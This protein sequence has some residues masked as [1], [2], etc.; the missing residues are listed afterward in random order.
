MNI[1]RVFVYKNYDEIK[2][3]SIPKV[4][5]VYDQKEINTH[6]FIE[7]IN[8]CKKNSVNITYLKFPRFKP[9]ADYDKFITD[10]I[11]QHDTLNFQL[12]H[13]DQEI[14]KITDFKDNNHLNLSGARKYSIALNSFL[15]D[16]KY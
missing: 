14:F 3:E 4:G 13:V 16:N 12:F 8:L 9:V 5:S 6:A 2:I 1:W 10:L 11:I 15:N 7:I